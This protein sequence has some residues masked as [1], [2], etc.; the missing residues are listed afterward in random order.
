MGVNAPELLLIKYADM[1]E[2]RFAAYAY[3]PDGST[4]TIIG[5]LPAANGEP[6]TV[7]NAPVLELMVYAEM[8]FD[9]FRAA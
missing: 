5:T 3:L 8:A 4:R 7:A 6:A 9:P 1:V 2:S